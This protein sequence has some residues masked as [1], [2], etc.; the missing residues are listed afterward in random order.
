MIR[1]DTVAPR[2]SGGK[3][4]ASGDDPC[5]SVAMTGVY[6][7]NPARAGMIP[8]DSVCWAV[9]FC[10]PRASGDDPPVLVLL[11]GGAT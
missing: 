5:P 4:R 3:P 8:L 10:K 11:I 7:V 6:L 2:V 9:A 1:D